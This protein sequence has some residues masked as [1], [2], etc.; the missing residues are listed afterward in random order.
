MKVE[1]PEHEVTITKPFA[2][3]RTDVTFAEWDNCVAAGACPKA[4]DYGWGRGDQPVIDVSWESAKGYV[5][6]LKR[7]T[8]KD[9]RLLSEAEWDT[10]RGRAVRSAGH[11]AVKRRSSAIMRGTTGTPNTR[12]TQSP[13]RSPM[14][15]AF[16]ICTATL[17]SG[18]RTPIMQAMAEHRWTVPFGIKE[19]T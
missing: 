12:R 10:L 15:L 6:W 5:Q 13:R 19:A 3:G 18:S 2:I 14:P 7:M 16:T 11:L 4:S 9:Y 1:R 17:T 8:G